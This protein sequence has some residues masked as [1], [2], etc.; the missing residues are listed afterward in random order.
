MM[1]S[2][3]ES[4]LITGNIMSMVM[5]SGR[6]CRQSSIAC[7]PSSASPAISMPGSAARISMWRLRTVTESSTTRTRIFLIGCA[8][9]TDHRRDHSQ[10]IGLVEF[11]LDDVAV[12][13][14]VTP[15]LAVFR[16]IAR[17][18]QDRRSVAQHRIGA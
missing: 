11:A 16:C 1:Y 5:T 4:P 7:L 9:S 6:V 17:G 13:A 14:G 3:A 15:A 8:I 10:Q 18:H 2:V 12:G